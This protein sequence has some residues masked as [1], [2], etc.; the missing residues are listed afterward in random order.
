MKKQP[1]TAVTLLFA[2]GIVIADNVNLD[3]RWPFGLSCCTLLIAMA[4]QRARNYSL[5]LLLVTA[6][7]ANLSLETAIF[8]PCDIRKIASGVPALA[9]VH[10]RLTETPFQ[11]V[12]ERG[13]RESW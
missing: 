7:A 13:Q 11:R 12:Y 10:G 5:A 2:L 1:L 6:G 9:T 8:S 4:S 3:W